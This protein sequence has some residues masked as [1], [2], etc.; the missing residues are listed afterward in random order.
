VKEGFAY[1]RRQ[2]PLLSTFAVDLNAMIFGMPRALFPALATD[3]FKVGPSGLG[4]LYAA[5]GAGAL[6]GALLTGWVSRISRQGMAVLWAVLVWG[7]AIVAF[8]FTQGAFWLALLFLAIAG[9]ADVVSAVFRGTILQLAVPDSLRGRVSAV[10]IVVVTS[11]PRLGDMEAG[12]VAAL[13]SVQFSVVSGG[14]LCVAGVAVLAA[15]VPS[16]A[17]YRADPE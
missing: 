7:A 15:L 9:A 17:R 12:A 6:A 16:F 13:T 5:P 14:L 10:H 4:L 3:V 8:G 1:L 2:P 11:G